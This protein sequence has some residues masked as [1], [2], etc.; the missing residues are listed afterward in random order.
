[1]W[2]TR[3]E[4]ISRSAW[5]GEARNASIPKRAM[6]YREPTMAIISIAQQDKPNWSGHIDFVCAHSTARSSVVSPN[7][8]SSSSTPSSCSKTLGPFVGQSRRSDFRP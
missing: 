8:C 5:R 2:A 4:T 7:F 6:S 1:L 3:P